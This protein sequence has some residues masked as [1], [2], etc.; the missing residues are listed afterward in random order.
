VTAYVA[1]LRA[2]NVGGNNKVPMAPLREALTAAG[3]DDVST[4][5][6]SGNV[7][8]ASRKSSAT[9][10]KVV[11]DAIEDA[12]GLSIGVVVRTG[13]ELAAVAATNPFLA[14]E[15]DRDPKTL[16]VVFLSGEPTAA[17]A[18]KLDP[19]RSPPDAFDVAGSEIYLSYPGGSGTSKLTL[20]YLERTLGVRGTARNWRTVQR[21][22]ALV[23]S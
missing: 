4:V 9:V 6:Q 15:P 5:L 2:V 22:A 7:V 20:D 21:L 10:G 12:F 8:F 11:G 16:H 19:E 18:A 17:A 1:F 3:L 14:D 23:E 13:A